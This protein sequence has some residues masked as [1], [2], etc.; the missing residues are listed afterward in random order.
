MNVQPDT[1]TDIEIRPAEIADAGSLAR[2]YNF[3][4]KETIVTFEEEALD[5]ADMVERLLDV[6]RESFPW[7]VAVR[8]GEVV[9]YAYATKWKPRYGYRFSAEVT[10]YL[11][12][13]CGGRGIG[14]KLYDQLLPMLKA[15]GLHM[16]FGGIALPNDASV[17]FHEKF[18]FVKVA[19][20]HEVGIKFDRWIDVGYWERVL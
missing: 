5:A 2:I 7:L 12:R 18:G 3:Y 10:V 20:F 14:S 16:A 8:G 11:D 9:G 17:A 19:Q 6:Q 13:T 15:L 1:A 4:I